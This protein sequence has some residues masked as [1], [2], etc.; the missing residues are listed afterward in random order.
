[1]MTTELRLEHYEIPAASLGEENPLPAF[2]TAQ[3]D[4]PVTVEPSVSPEDAARLGWRT[5]YR[6]LPHRMQDGYDRV[7]RPRAFHACVLENDYVRATF[8]PEVG[9]RLVSLIHKP[10]QR[11]LLDCNPVFQPANLALRN[12]WFSGGV[13]WNTCHFGHYYLTCSPV[14]AAK[15]TGT[16]GEP[17]LRLYEWDRVKGFAWQIDFHLPP[18]SRFL[19]TRV[20][21]INPRDQELPMYW[22]TNMAVPERPGTRVLCPADT[23]LHSANGK[24][25][26]QMQMPI[27]ENTDVTYG[28][29]LP[30]SREFFFRIPEGQ[31][32]WE[33]ALNSDGSGL[34]HASTA[35]LKG[36]KAFYWGTHAGGRRWQEFL[37]VPGRAYLEIQAGLA[38]TQLESVPM[39]A[40]AEW[41]WTEA[42]GLLEADA[43]IVHSSD[44]QSAWRGAETAL[45]SALPQARLDAFDQTFAATT[46]RGAD[47][48]LSPG[49]GWG[50]LERKRLAARKQ[51]D[52]IP[53][54][55]DFGCTGTEQE[56]WL[57]LLEKKALSE[58][59]AE[60]GT[61]ALMVQD[62]WR[63]LL[64]TALQSG[65]GDHW[66]SWWHLG[67]MRLENF[68]P[69]GAK[70]AWLRSLQHQRTAYA[71]RNLAVLASR[72]PTRD[73]P[74][75][76]KFHTAECPIPEACELLRQAWEA[77]PKMT[78]LALEYAQMLV[79]LNRQTELH[80][81]VSDLP[82]YVQ[83]N[84][85][86]Q[87]FIALAALQAGTLDDIEKL[88]EYDFATIREGEVTL[89]DIWFSYHERRIAEAEKIPID[90]ALRQRI[91]KEFPPPQRIDFRVI[92]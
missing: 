67:N 40:G 46:T 62:E 35:R 80:R 26:A 71:L 45:N 50:A 70:E 83:K 72:E 69:A 29:K 24:Q 63:A 81:F 84:E 47:K 6:V 56:P 15:V 88:F 1:M 57:G 68:D 91:Q 61:G 52:R 87:I 38:C 2:R 76:V 51:P 79:Q 49:S 36:R 3:Q 20:R 27:Y 12:A 7:K 48:I 33:A 82:P 54:E 89:T 74:P 53:V 92:T 10:R 11:D 77:G 9:G 44:W 8:L 30:S 31:R 86:I 59:S 22:W 43:R 41:T 19:F 64:E 28:A 78:A 85:R 17:V 39:P 55:L 4:L 21:L 90:D 23:A 58:T 32:R 16:Q 34:V 5:G 18:G 25:I 65:L 75:A 66:L 60:Q 37:S 73:K 14:F 42:F 13:E